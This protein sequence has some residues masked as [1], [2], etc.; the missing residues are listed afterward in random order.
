MSNRIL[1]SA[2]AL[3]LAAVF[4]ILA[5]G[6]AVAQEASPVGD[7]EGTISAQG[8]DIPIEFHITAGDDGTL[9]A[10]LDTPSQGGFGLALEDVAFV[11]GVFTFG[12]SVVPGGASYEGTLSEDGSALAGTWSQ[13]GNVVE[14]NMTK[15]DGQ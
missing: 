12:L 10:T 13:G 15:G 9:S 4:G 5:T 1:R 11:D 14:L 8:M 3:A 7:W 6:D 2:R